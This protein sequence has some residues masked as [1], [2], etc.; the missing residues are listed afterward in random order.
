MSNKDQRI[1]ECGGNNCECQ[2]GDVI[3]SEY[4]VDVADPKNAAIVATLEWAERIIEPPTQ[5]Q[6]QKQLEYFI[7]LLTNK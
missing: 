2:T 4:L 6:F 3:R 7:N 1:C 5:E